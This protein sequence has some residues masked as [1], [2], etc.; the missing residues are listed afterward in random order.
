MNRMLRKR[1]EL[2]S[3]RGKAG[4]RAKAEKRSREAYAMRVVGGF[5]TWGCIG[6][7]TLELLYGDAY[8]ERHLAVM[9][10]GEC[11]KPRTPRGVL[12]CI[13]E[14]VDGYVENAGRAVR[15]WPEP[16]YYI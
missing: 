1:K 2:W 14:M 3:K 8:S 9:V 5:T 11:R 6:Q 12:R 4:V 16:E 10:D 13:A 7:H 15:R